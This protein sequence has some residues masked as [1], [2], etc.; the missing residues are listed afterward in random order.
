MTNTHYGKYHTKSFQ[1]GARDKGKIWNASCVR[2]SRIDRRNDCVQEVSCDARATDQTKQINIDMI[3]L[4]LRWHKTECVSSSSMSHIEKI[5]NGDPS[6]PGRARRHANHNIEW[7]KKRYFIV[8]KITHL[9]IYSL[10][11]DNRICFVWRRRRR[12]RWKATS[13]VWCAMC[14]WCVDWNERHTE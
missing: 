5:A 7:W 9:F 10:R 1:C 6:K 12:R 2:A 8:H 3:A 4:Q 13:V 14:V 11:N